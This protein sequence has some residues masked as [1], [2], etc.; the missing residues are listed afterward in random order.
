MK[1]LFTLVISTMTIVASL[2]QNDCTSPTIIGGLPYSSVGLTTCGTVNDYTAAD[3]CAGSY[4]S[5]EDY[6]FEYTPAADVCVEI[7]ISNGTN[8]GAILTLGCPDVGTCVSEDA[9]WNDTKVF[10]G[11]SLKGGSTYYLVVDSKSACGTF[12]VD[13]TSYGGATGVDCATPVVVTPAMLPYSVTNLS[14]CC[15][16]NDYS[17]ADACGSAYMNGEDFVYEYTPAVD[18]CITV[19]ITSAQGRMG[20]FLL[21]GCPDV[22]GTTCLDSD[23]LGAGGGGTALVGGPI[24]GGT[25]YKIVIARGTNF[26]NCGPF[27]ITI[28]SITMPVTGLVCATPYSIGALP[29]SHTGATTYCH[30]DDYDNTDACSSVYMMGDDVVYTFTPPTDS[31]YSFELDNTSAGGKIHILD[32][33]PDVGGTTCL[34]A[35]NDPILSIDLLSSTTYYV[36]VAS[37]PGIA[38]S[39]NYDL[40]VGYGVCSCPGGPYMLGG[41]CCSSAI[42][43]SNPDTSWC[44]NTLGSTGWTACKPGNMESAFCGSIENNQNYM[45]V[46]DS[47][48]ICFSFSAP[49][50]SCGDGIQVWIYSTPDCVTYTGHACAGPAGFP[51]GSVPFELCAS[52]LTVGNTYYMMI[53]G[54]AGASCDGIR[55]NVLGNQVLPVSWLSI[56]AQSVEDGVELMWSTAQEINNDYFEIEKSL[57]A[58]H[59][60]P[61]GRVKGAGS[62][63]QV[64]S[65]SIIDYDPEVGINYYRVKQVDID[66]QFEYSKVVSISFESEIAISNVF[67]NPITDNFYF[68][69]IST[70]K[71]NLAIS[72]FDLMGR[73][74][75]EKQ[76]AVG[77]G[78][79][80][81]TVEADHLSQGVYFLSVEDDKLRS[82]YKRF[83]KN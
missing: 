63:Y 2:A 75:S 23:N 52:G 18:E 60:I 1:L 77:P 64:S 3:A 25:T 34:D 20:V 58:Q 15:S 71:S 40:S 68:E 67:P 11:G 57:D 55:I 24:T 49:D 44:T 59:F 70:E 62:T 53:D 27:D 14:T 43:I 9:D 26:G 29:Y 82:M 39:F 12:D 51:I 21:D 17:S 76:V 36:V 47:T 41:D 28:N 19:E 32:G 79:A 5:Q 16:G 6:V 22:G 69:I 74:I 10:L 81:I 33:C 8:M 46:A 80:R 38:Q 31:C 45:F 54:F 65:Y 73:K 56:E 4:M 66:K 78:K 30:D 35:G 13:V 42:P 48:D 61:I 7:V 37:A 50:P 72:V 83:M